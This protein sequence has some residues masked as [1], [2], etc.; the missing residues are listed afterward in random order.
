MP[1]IQYYKKK[2][3]VTRGHNACN[4]MLQSDKIVV[5]TKFSITKATKWK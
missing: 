5:T 2:V 1:G 4:E 3:I